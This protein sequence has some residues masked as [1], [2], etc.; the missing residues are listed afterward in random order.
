MIIVYGC[1]IFAVPLNFKSKICNEEIDMQHFGFTVEIQ[2]EDGPDI[3]VKESPAWY[4]IIKIAGILA[5]IV[6]V[7]SQGS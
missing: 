6:L 7:L 2:K 5:F 4:K 3:K 1:I